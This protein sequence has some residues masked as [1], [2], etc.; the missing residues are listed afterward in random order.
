MVRVE[1]EVGLIPGLPHVQFTGL[2]DLVIKESL[3]RIKSAIRNQGYEWPRARQIIINLRPSYLKKSSQGLELAIACALLWKTGQVKAPSGMDFPIH[4]YGELSLDGK[5]FAP[6]NWESLPPR[7]EGILT[8]AIHTNNYLCPLFQINELSDLENPVRIPVKSLGDLLKRPVPSSSIQF[9]AGAANILS[10]VATGEHSLLL[11]GETGSGKSTLAE[12]LPYLLAP[13]SLEEFQVS[14]RIWNRTG[15]ELHWRPF[16]SP[17]HSTTPLSMIGGGHP[18]FFGE[19]TKAHGGILFMDEY[20]EFQSRVQESLREPVERGKIYVARKGESK[21]FPA[22][23]LLIAATNLCPCGD[24]VPSKK[25]PCSYSL[26]KCFSHIERLNGPMLDRFDILVFSNQ[27]RGEWSV[28]IQSL[29]EKVEKAIQFR[30]SRNQNLPN[31]RLS[32][33]ELESTL[34]IFSKETQLP[35]YL[36]SKRRRR[37]ILRVARTLADLENSSLIKVHHIEEAKKFSLVPF[38]QLKNRDFLQ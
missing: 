25:M 35:S 36:P 8:G 16:V 34:D 7:K 26:R 17:H 6:K 29:R 38:V 31:A 18:V 32:I 5:V 28:S 22:R 13:P 21:I 3:M 14:R 23:F 30:D 19:I 37:A 24:L 12:H 27:W 15:K 1:V 11:A 33:A 10:L 9:S 2:P 4:V 20:L